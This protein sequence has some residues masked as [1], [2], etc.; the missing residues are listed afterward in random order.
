MPLHNAE[1]SSTFASGGITLRNPNNAIDG[2]F[3]TVSITLAT[4]FDYWIAELVNRTEI[5]SLFVSTNLDTVQRGY[6][7][8]LKV[9]TR[10][11]ITDQWKSCKEDVKWVKDYNHHRIECD[12]Q[13]TAKHIRISREGTSR[14]GSQ[15]LTLSE[16]TV[17]GVPIGKMKL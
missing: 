15:G 2:D 14:T 8:N 3:S 9:E 7:R 13:T 11:K 4:N 12:N 1:Q 6:H 16:V 5:I 17:L 10:L